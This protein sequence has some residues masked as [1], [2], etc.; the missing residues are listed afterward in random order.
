[1]K[2][3]S[4][5][6]PLI[7]QQPSTLQGLVKHTRDLQAHQQYY[8]VRS[9]APRPLVVSYTGELNGDICGLICKDCAG[10]S[11]FNLGHLTEFAKLS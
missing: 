5:V 10:L 3:V 6:N 1:M 8:F 11:S 4:P 2:C 7:L 9:L